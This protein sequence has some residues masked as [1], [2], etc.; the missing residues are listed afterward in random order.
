MT[1]I[2]DD[3]RRVLDLLVQGRITAEEAEGLLAAME[4]GR[5]ADGVPHTAAAG[6]RFLRIQ[7]DRQASDPHGPRRVNVRVPY[8]LVK[9]GMR[10]GA[11]LKSVGGRDGRI[12]ERLRARGIDLDFSQLD[13]ESFEQLLEHAG[14]IT[15]DVD[16]GRTTIRITRE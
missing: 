3:R 12:A 15:V 5:D 9:S 10:I 8:A 2:A 6:G 11:L 13:A 16:D 7:I 14:E 4:E 1:A